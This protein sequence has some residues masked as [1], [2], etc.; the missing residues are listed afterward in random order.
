MNKLT[1]DDFI[2]LYCSQCEI[3]TS[4]KQDVRKCPYKNE[5]VTGYET[6]RGYENEKKR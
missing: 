1:I 3:R 2:S 5:C 6:L 4:N